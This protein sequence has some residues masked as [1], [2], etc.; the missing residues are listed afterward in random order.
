MATVGVHW[1]PLVAFEW[2]AVFQP[3]VQ[4][5]LCA[6]VLERLRRCQVLLQHIALHVFMRDKSLQKQELV[7]WALNHHA[8][9]TTA[10]AAGRLSLQ[11]SQDLLFG[12]RDSL[13]VVPTLHLLQVGA[14]VLCLSGMIV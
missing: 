8:E 4:R 5:E 14:Q 7:Q 6:R 11:P 9:R 1:A 3:L 13:L 2:L 12:A 10:R